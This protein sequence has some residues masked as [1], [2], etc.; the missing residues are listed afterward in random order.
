MDRKRAY[1]VWVRAIPILHIQPFY[2]QIRSQ[3]Q[4]TR[5]W[6]NHLCSEGQNKLVYKKAWFYSALV[7]VS[8]NGNETTKIIV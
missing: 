4:E 5:I 7:L 3:I 8:V 2:L 1:L 6:S